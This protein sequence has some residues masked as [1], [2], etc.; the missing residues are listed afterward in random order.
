MKVSY[1]IFELQQEST[2]KIFPWR[3]HGYAFQTQTNPA[4]QL[5]TFMQNIHR[6]DDVSDAEAYVSRLQ[7]LEATPT[8]S[9]SRR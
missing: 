6:V 3:F 4:T 1:R 7:G 9:S 5:V 8:G 2:L